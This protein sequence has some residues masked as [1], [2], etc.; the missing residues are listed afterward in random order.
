MSTRLLA[1]RVS[2]MIPRYEK[3]FI[4]RGGVTPTDPLEFHLY[5]LA[6]YWSRLV[7]F[8]R[9]APSNP[10]AFIDGDL[11]A[12]VQVGSEFAHKLV[13]PD[14][15]IYGQWQAY[16]AH[17]QTVLHRRP[18]GIEAVETA[19]QAFQACV[20]DLNYDPWAT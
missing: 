8:C 18:V 12:C 7:G 5:H 9:Q 2:E 17:T 11:G 1:E 19:S 3:H 16:W 10:A 14:S 6:R 13:G 15:P 20:A 4:E